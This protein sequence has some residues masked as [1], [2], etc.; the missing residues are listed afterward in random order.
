MTTTR[1]Q[2]DGMT[3][4]NCVTH[5]QK[6]LEAVPGVKDATVQLDEDAIVQHENASEEQMLRAISAAGDYKG[7]VVQ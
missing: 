5:V 2:I 4:L 3:C 6:A 1:I 7:K